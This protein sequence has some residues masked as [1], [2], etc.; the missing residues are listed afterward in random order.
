MNSLFGFTRSRKDAVGCV[1]T[2]VWSFKNKLKTYT[3]H[4]FFR[5]KSVVTGHPS[6]SS[7]DL[8]LELPLWPCHESVVI[9]SLLPVLPLV[10]VGEVSQVPTSYSCFWTSGNRHSP[11]R[12]V[13]PQRLP[14]SSPHPVRKSVR[15]TR[16]RASDQDNTSI[17]FRQYFIFVDA[18]ILSLK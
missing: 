10:P 17:E 1:R 12:L 18:K 15:T 16:T 13:F 2:W 11:G 5:R 14:V 8:N 7:S 6:T 4:P 3:N 9:V